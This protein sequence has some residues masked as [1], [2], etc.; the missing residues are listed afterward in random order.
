[1]GKNVIL[2]VE[3]KGY[4]VNV[5]ECRIIYAEASLS[6]FFHKIDL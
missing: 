3:E 5:T 1:M 2:L 4:K 6:F